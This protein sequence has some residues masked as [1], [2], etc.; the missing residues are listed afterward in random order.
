MKNKGYYIIGICMTFLFSFTPSSFS[1][2]I[3][4]L[5]NIDSMERDNTQVKK[6]KYIPDTTQK[7]SEGDTAIRRN[8]SERANRE[9]KN[10]YLVPEKKK[11]K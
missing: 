1:Q 10:M 8:R 5:K 7:Y 2:N 9:D 4:N 6:E 3:D 11:T